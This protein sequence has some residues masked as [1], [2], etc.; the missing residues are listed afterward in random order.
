MKKIFLFLT[1]FSVI[2]ASGCAMSSALEEKESSDGQNSEQNETDVVKV[3]IL[4]SLS[5]TM[6]ISEVSL[7]DAELMAI[8]EINNSGGLLGKKIEP[9]IE[10]GASDWPTFAEKAKKLLQQDKVATI[11]GGWTSASRKA[12]LPVVEQ[13]KGLLWYPVQYEGMESSPNIFYTGATTNQQIV[14]AVSWLLNNKGKKF[15]LIGSDYVFPRTANSIIKAQLKAEGGEV[16]VE[17]YTP[18]GHTDYSTVINK[19]KKV[20][21]DVVFNTL[22]GDSN[23]AFFKQLKDAGITSKDVTVMSV[24]IAEEE[25]RGIGGEVLAGH[26]AVWN[27]FQTT[28]IPENKAFVEKYKEAYGE[29]RVTDD[30]IEAAYIAVHL[31]AE[32]VKK[33]GSFEVEKVKEAAKGIEY[34]APGGTVKIE[35]ENQHLWKTVRIGEIQPDGQF[36]EIWNSGEPVKPDPY[37][38]SYSWA[39]KLSKNNE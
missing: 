32:A 19:M 12:M 18:L 26:L 21:P 20:K 3:G 23:V 24:S 16:V 9:V 31:W 30:P 35:G 39:E 13:N 34:K 5:G 25:I 7:K 8:E 1:I 10:D 29:E 4:H 38:K 37:L 14:P 27:Y 6:A 2:F 11:F 15:F 17:E 28:D 36:K 33:A 22:N